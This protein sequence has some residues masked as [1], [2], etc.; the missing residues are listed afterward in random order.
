MTIMCTFQAVGDGLRSMLI[1]LG[2]QLLFY[3]PFLYIFNRIWG[4][5][6]LMYAQTAAD[7]CTTLLAILV[8]LPL[9][10]RLS[11]LRQNKEPEYIDIMSETKSI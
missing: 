3:I 11:K 10:R 6:G 1:N 7:V 4:L 8:G 5:S 2:R 9:L